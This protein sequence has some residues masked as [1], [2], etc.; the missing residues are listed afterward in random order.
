VTLVI[1]DDAGLGT[2]LGASM[3]VGLVTVVTNVAAM[4][5]VGLYYHHFKHRF[6]WSWG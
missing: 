4:R 6:A 2:M 1:P 5:V 3:V